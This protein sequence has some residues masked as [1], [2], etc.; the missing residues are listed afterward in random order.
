MEIKPRGAHE[1]RL[2]G[3]DAALRPGE[4]GG[5]HGRG[6]LVVLA[7]QALDSMMEG[8]ASGGVEFGCESSVQ[9]SGVRVRC[10]SVNNICNNIKVEHLLQKRELSPNRLTLPTVPTAYV[11]KTIINQLFILNN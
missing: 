9:V 2:S 11:P 6:P 4:N 10:K 7:A 5:R 3:A 8:Y 1:A